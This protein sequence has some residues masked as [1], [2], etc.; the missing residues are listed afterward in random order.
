MRTTGTWRR[1]ATAMLAA[2]VV[3]GATAVRAETTL[4]NVSYDPTREL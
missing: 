3:M 4:L 2:I 1:T